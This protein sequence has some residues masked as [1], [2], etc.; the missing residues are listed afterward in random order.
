MV[1]RSDISFQSRGQRCAGW[2][3]APSREAAKVPCVVMAHGTTG[4]MNFGLSRYAQRFAAA[5]FAVLVFDY[6][7]FGASE[8]RPRQLINVKR[9]VTDWEAAIRFARTLSQIDPDR[10]AL[11]GTSL[12]GGHVVTVAA[13]DPTVAAVV[14]QMPFM[15]VDPHGS[16]PRSGRVTRKLFTAAIRDAL[17]GVVGR[18]PLTVP[19]VGEP[20]TV[21]VFTGVEDYAVTRTLA[22][23]APEWRNEMAARSLFSLIRYRPGALAGRLVMPLLVC[24]ADADTAASVPLAV[25]AAQ[26]APCGELRRYPGGHFAA[27]LGEVFE[28]MVT[29]EI[30]FLHRHLVATAAATTRG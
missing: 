14:A 6:R 10:I 29:D 8:G 7:Y 16:S 18:P 13:S 3:Y 12:S 21:A 27:Y 9:Q 23:G 2:L 28:H 15:G 26:Q 19:M 24:V 1:T 25:R 5:G 22:A 20:G 4:T 11:W 17:R 30:D